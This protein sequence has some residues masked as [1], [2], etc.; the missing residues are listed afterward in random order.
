MAC[1]YI[2]YGEC[3][4]RRHQPA[5][6]PPAALTGA[7]APRAA[8]ASDGRI[9]G[10]HDETTASTADGHSPADAIWRA[11]ASGLYFKAREKMYA[12][13]RAR[14]VRHHHEGTGPKPHNYD[15]AGHAEARQGGAL[16]RAFAQ[17][18][19]A[20]LCA[21]VL[22][23]SFIL[24]T[25]AA[26]PNDYFFWVIIELAFIAQAPAR[27]RSAP[28][29]NAAMTTPHGVLPGAAAL[30]VPPLPRPFP[31]RHPHQH[32]AHRLHAGDSNLETAPAR[33]LPLS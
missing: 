26:P 9:D 11:K 32:L 19:A 22:V 5:P 20:M 1:E 6:P 4:R 29:A 14:A 12:K 2:R 18:D 27:P 31:D 23:T 8:D 33:S 16:I 25:S 7:R 17:W 15:G 3:R 28:P 21:T 13:L 24:Y 30:A 10:K